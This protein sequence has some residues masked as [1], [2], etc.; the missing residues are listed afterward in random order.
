[1]VI[2]AHVHIWSLDARDQPWIPA[3][4]PLRRSFGL[5]ELA[6][7]VAATPVESVVLVQVINDAEETADLLAA[8]DHPLVAGVVGWVDLAA[9]G[10]R[11]AVVELSA[12]GRLVG[13]RHQA[14]AEDDTAGWLLSG[15]VDA[16]LTV[17]DREGLAFDLIVRPEHLAAAT[18]VARAHPSLCL[19]L[20]HLGKPPI[21]SG[22]LEPWARGVR[23]LAAEPNV[24]CK[25]SGLQTVA[26][27]DWTDADLAPFLHV[28]LE[29]FGPDRLMFGSDWP[30]SSTA[31]SYLGVFEAVDRFTAE[32]SS[33]EKAAIF[34]STARA[35]YRLDRIRAGQAVKPPS[36][37]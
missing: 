37:E 8:A 35:T 10:C 15:R 9:A 2:D 23:L 32:L 4:S 13:I 31:A 28:A 7:A 34:G 17:L 19:V 6:A 24:R 3:A 14:L 25:L 18:D 26:S 20:D 21:A 1:M 5:D 12:T 22:E 11:D 30:V 33:A 16:A 27:A 29:A 36:T